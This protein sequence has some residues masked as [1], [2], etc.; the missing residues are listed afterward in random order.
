MRHISVSVIVPVYNVEQYIERCA[1]SLFEQTI[2]N[3][4]YI[5][6]NDCTPDKSMD[7]LHQIM[8]QYPLRMSQVKILN[9]ET[10]KGTAATRNTGLMHASGEFIGWVDSDDWVDHKMFEDMYKRANDSN[11]DIVW[12]DIY[13]C[14]SNDVKEWV[15]DRQ[16]CDEDS[17]AL[18]R[19][20]LSGGL[21][22]SLCNSIVSRKL[23]INNEILFSTDVDLMEDKLASV[24]L[25]YYAQKCTYIPQAYYFYNKMNTKSMT[26]SPTNYA[27]NLSDGIRSIQ[28]IISFL[29]TNEKEIDFSQELIHAKIAFKDYYFHSHSVQGYFVWKDVFPE[30]NSYFITKSATPLKNKIIGWL[31]VND[32]WRTLKAGIKLRNFIKRLSK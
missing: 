22:G 10:N 13:L 3:V 23:Y 7:I 31:I 9:H 21:H 26:S 17:I 5:F 8:E 4:E 25:R 12:C 32:Y 16:F 30:V 6:V 2:E 1:R 15:K 18:V 29:E 11:A 19:S 28:S 24:K 20:L 14:Y 27:K